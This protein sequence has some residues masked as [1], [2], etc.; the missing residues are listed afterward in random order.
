[1]KI[2]HSTV[3]RCIKSLMAKW[4]EQVSLCHEMYYTIIILRSW[5]L[6][7]VGL[8]FGCVVLLSK[9]HLN[10]LERWFTQL[11]LLVCFLSWTT[12]FF[13]EQY[14]SQAMQVSQFISHSTRYLLLLSGNGQHGMK[15]SPTDDQQLDLNSWPLEFNKTV[16]LFIYAK[17]SC[18]TV[19]PETYLAREQCTVNTNIH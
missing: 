14:S 12:S 8:N 5:V 2:K 6:T 10:Q 13:Q 16:I 18:I 17:Y 3:S 11:A 1:M 15:N 9:L 7:P 19:C 4:L